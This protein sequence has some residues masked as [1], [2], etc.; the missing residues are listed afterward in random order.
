MPYEDKELV[1]VSCTVHLILKNYWTCSDIHL[2]VT[3]GSICSNAF[4]ICSNAFSRFDSHPRE[5]IVSMCLLHI[6]VTQWE[7]V[8]FWLRTMSS[9]VAV[10][11]R[12]L[13]ME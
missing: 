6:V 4:G 8:N 1:E 10:V 9:H 11:R 12:A 2:T 13:T 7:I 5:H 3:K